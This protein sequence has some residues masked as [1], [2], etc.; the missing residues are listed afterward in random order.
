MY[1]PFSPRNAIVVSLPFIQHRYNHKFDQITLSSK[2]ILPI[3][4][5]RKKMVQRSRARARGSQAPARGLHEPTAKGEA[6]RPHAGT[7]TCTPAAPAIHLVADPV[8]HRTSMA[9]A[10]VDGEHHHSWNK[11]EEEQND[12]KKKKKEKSKAARV[13]PSG[14]RARAA[15]LPQTRSAIVPC[16][17]A[18]RCPRRSTVSI[19]CACA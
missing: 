12:K 14:Y 3:H 15:R 2:Y 18:A 7:T 16:A 4:G 1:K 13:A 17:Y 10:F 19:A 9:V 6:P 5:K 8:G 11:E